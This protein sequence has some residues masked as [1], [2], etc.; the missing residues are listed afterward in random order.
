MKHGRSVCLIAGLLLLAQAAPLHADQAPVSNPP[1]DPLAAALAD[2]SLPNREGGVP[3]Q[4]YTR[5][6]ARSNPCWVCHTQKN[7]RNLMDDWELQAKYDFSAV[8]KT[9]HWS[10]LFKD[11]RPAIARISDAQALDYI[12]QDNYTPLRNVHQLLEDSVTA[13]KA[14]GRVYRDGRAG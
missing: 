9:N 1:S 14:S 5:T 11:R 10:N 3:P 12:R 7:G 6:G 8:G 4:C 13:L 2:N